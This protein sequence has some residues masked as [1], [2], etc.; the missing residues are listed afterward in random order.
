MKAISFFLGFLFSTTLLAQTNNSVALNGTPF[1]SFPTAVSVSQLNTFTVE[2]WVNWGGSG[3]G[4]I[5]AETEIGNNAPMFSI[6][7]RSSDGGGIELTF[8]DNSSVGLSLQPANGV[9]AIGRWTHVAVVRTSATNMKVYIDGNLTDDANFTPPAA[10]APNSVN[11]GVRRRVSNTDPFVGR[12]DELRIWNVARTQA[13]IKASMFGSYLAAN[14]AGLVARYSFNETNGIVAANSST[15]TPGTNGTFNVEPGWAPSPIQFGANSLHFD[16]VD[17]MMTAPVLSTATTNVTLETW[18]YH[19]GGTGTDHL[20]MS[21]GAPG[22]NGYAFFINTQRR[23][24]LILGGVG[25][26][27]TPAFVLTNQWCH[28]A[29]VISTTGVTVYLNGDVVYTN[30]VLPNT[31]TGNFIVG[32]RPGPGQ[33]YDGMVDEIRFWNTARTQAEIQ[34][35]MQW[36]IDPA[37]PGLAT[38]YTFNQGITNG[39]NSGLNTVIDMAGNKNGTL[40]GFAYSGTTSNY[41]AQGSNLVVLPVNWLSF[42]ANMQQ[43]NVLLQ[44]STANEENNREFEIQ[45]SVNASDWTTIGIQKGQDNISTVANY[46]YLHTT[47]AP[48]KNYYR[49]KQTDFNHQFSYSKT[50]SVS[51][52]SANKSLS[53]ISNPVVG[54]QLKFRLN[55]SGSLP[56]SLYTAE[57]K[58]IRTQMLQTGTHQFDLSGFTKGIYLLQAGD[59]TERVIVQ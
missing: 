27:N 53:L 58:L 25:T 18:V 38:Y 28:L 9:I 49:I 3:N 14:T 7:P 22:T 41:V 54:G 19:Q 30:N 35:G 33:P 12:I 57:G 52:L 8:R 23:L 47:P 55:T 4:C 6:I 29:L 34:A 37:T 44:W 1:A 16:Q 43:Q 32:Y 39:N 5:Y 21:N 59:V 11:A 26:F 2:A 51:A 17:D 36:E 56:V 15:N 42:T 50:V 10:W 20:L 40:T 13:Q 31:P 46:S 24:V 48:G 45:H